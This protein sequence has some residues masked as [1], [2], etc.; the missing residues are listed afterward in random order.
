MGLLH[1]RLLAGTTIGAV[2]FAVMILVAL[3]SPHGR[4]E[5]LSLA[6]Y[7]SLALRVRGVGGVAWLAHRDL[8]L[9]RLR[10]VEVLA[11]AAYAAH[12][13]WKDFEHYSRLLGNAPGRRPVAGCVA[14]LLNWVF[15]I[16][17]YG[18]LIPNDWRRSLRM[19][20]GMAVIPLAVYAATWFS[21]PPSRT[22]PP[23]RC[24]SC[25]PWRG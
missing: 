14:Q 5:H 4:S 15:L 20:T 24:L 10:V 23:R 19:L 17:I 25:L 11:V 12:C 1:R 7:A 13:A 3:A 22:G 9:S 8:S 16:F 6:L 2:A 21:F 18:I